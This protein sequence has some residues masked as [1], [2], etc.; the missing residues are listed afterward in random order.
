MIRPDRLTVKASEAVQGATRLAQSRGNPIVNDAHL[1]M[2]LL[3]SPS[4]RRA[5]DDAI[6]GREIRAL[7]AELLAHIKGM[8]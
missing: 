5:I 6:P 2:A 8:R 7:Q 1:F 4:P 3:E